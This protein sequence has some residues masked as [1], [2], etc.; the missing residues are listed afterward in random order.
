M[1]KSNIFRRLRYAFALIIVFGLVITTNRIDNAHFKTAQESIE[2][3]YFDR[4]VAQ[5]LIYQTSK[6]LFENKLALLADTSTSRKM[7]LEH[8]L[9]MEELF[10][11]Y[12]KT[13]LTDPEAL[14]FEKLQRNFHQL[15]TLQNKRAENQEVDKDQAI[16]LCNRIEQN[17]NQLAEIQIKESRN[18]KLIARQSLKNNEMMS[19]IEI[20]LLIL[21]GLALQVVLFYKIKS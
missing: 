5:N 9:K 8:D 20:G 11:E 14:A 17:L 16:Q 19:K 13:R 4:V 2:S 21:I 1:A 12:A 6:V 3:V 15:T 7:I 10:E 18:L